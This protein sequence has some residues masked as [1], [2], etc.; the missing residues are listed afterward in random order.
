MKW[1]K[2]TA[3]AAVLAITL[4]SALGCNTVR[5]LGRDIEKGGEKLQDA[6]N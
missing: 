1:L 6:A 5:G 2:L 4:T 3:F